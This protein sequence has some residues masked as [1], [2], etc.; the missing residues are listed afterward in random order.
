MAKGMN[1]GIL[2]LLAVIGVVLGGVVSFFVYLG[3]RSA[4]AVPDAARPNSGRASVAARPDFCGLPERLGIARTL[5]VPKRPYPL[6]E[7]T[8][9]D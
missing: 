6:I 7:S 3:K 8:E 4:T 5:D 1:M 9:R 2:S